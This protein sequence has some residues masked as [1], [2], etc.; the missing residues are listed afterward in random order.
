MKNEKL[1]S[2][3]ISAGDFN[4]SCSRSADF[5]LV[6]YPAKANSRFISVYHRDIMIEGSMFIQVRASFDEKS[7]MMK[8]MLFIQ[9]N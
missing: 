1:G 6:S 2:R 9:S 4:Y 5:E 8:Y 7:F 3:Y